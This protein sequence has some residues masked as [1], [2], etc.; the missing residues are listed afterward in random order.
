MQYSLFVAPQVIGELETLLIPPSVES[1]FSC[2][3]IQTCILAIFAFFSQSNLGHFLAQRFRSVTLSLPTDAELQVETSALM[4]SKRSRE[5]KYLYLLLECFPRPEKLKK[6]PD[7]FTDG[8]VTSRAPGAFQR[9]VYLIVKKMLVSF[10]AHWK[11]GVTCC[12][13]PY[14]GFKVLR[15]SSA[16]SFKLRTALRTA[17]DRSTCCLW[18]FATMSRAKSHHCRSTTF[19][20]TCWPRLCKLSMCGARRAV[21]SSCDNAESKA[22]RRAAESF[23]GSANAAAQSVSHSNTRLGHL[24]R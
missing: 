17:K 16:S 22:W 21:A 7:M 11:A 13:K 8:S 4:L 5:R 18:D 2:I 14:L 15:S 6:L 10:W 9:T 3:S 1:S 24:A 23:T 12:A 20:I 19:S